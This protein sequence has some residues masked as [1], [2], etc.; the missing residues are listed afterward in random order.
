MTTSN[1]APL[2]WGLLQLRNAAEATGKEWEGWTKV[3]SKVGLATA[4]GGPGAGVAWCAW[5]RDECVLGADGEKEPKK[6]K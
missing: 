5:K 2:V 6:L 4:V 1:I 3:L